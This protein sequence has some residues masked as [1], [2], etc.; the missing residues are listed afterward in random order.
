MVGVVHGRGG[1][2]TNAQIPGFKIAAKTGTA[3]WGSGA[4]EKVAAWFAGFAPSERPRYAFAE[5]YEGK[6][7]RDDVH[8]GSHAAP[9]VAR[10]LK[11]LMKPEPKE[12]KGGGL[13]KRK[14]VEDEEEER[15]MQDEDDEDD[16]PRAVRP[17]V[18]ETV[19]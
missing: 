5:V 19:Q 17:R 10:V 9:V 18:V 16:E 6:E 12:P 8:G 14:K 1:T 4:K 2:A 13:R 3:Q 11:E 7:A 15:E